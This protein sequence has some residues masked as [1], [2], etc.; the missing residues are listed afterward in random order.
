V[1]RLSAS[2]A[3]QA[4]E[5]QEVGS[6]LN[7]AAE[8]LVRRIVSVKSQ[9][10]ANPTAAEFE[11]LKDE[12]AA[13]LERLTELEHLAH[14]KFPRQEEEREHL[15]SRLDL[16][17]S[18]VQPILAREQRSVEQSLALDSFY[19]N[20]E[21]RFRG[22]RAVIRARVEPYLAT[23]REAG[24]GTA[25]APVIDIGCGRGEWL[26]A[27]RDNVLIGR[28][29]DMNRVFIEA[30]RGL[31]LEVIEGDAIDSLR[32]M[33]EGSAG[34]VTAMHVVEHLPFEHVITLLDE[35]RRVLRPGGLIVVET[36][37]PENLSVAHH[38]FYMDPTHRNPLPPE[39][40]RWMVEA[41]GFDRAR[42]ERLTAARELNAPPLLQEDMPGASSINAVL[43]SLNAAPD[44][45]IVARRPQAE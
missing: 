6:V 40:L 37:N 20:L 12:Y 44:Y 11:T 41:C 2:E 32:A 25:E 19:A 30:C 13:A 27:L 17:T 15:K 31:G 23:V 36:P 26:E 28:G 33:H 38:W 3:G 9:L 5:I 16:M 22:D 8:C 43:A 42:I 39:V 45:A 18:A 7:L 35:I 1:D 24:A 10:A 29:I 21:N 4:Q 34:A 14:T